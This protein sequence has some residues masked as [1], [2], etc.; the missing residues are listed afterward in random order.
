L[1]LKSRLID[2]ESDTLPL[3][4]GLEYSDEKINLLINTFDKEWSSKPI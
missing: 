1:S 3:A 4:N 2:Y